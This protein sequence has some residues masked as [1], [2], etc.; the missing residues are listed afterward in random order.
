MRRLPLITLSTIAAVL[1]GTMVIAPGASAKPTVRPIAETPSGTVIQPQLFG[2][3]VFDVQNG[4]WPTIPIGALRLWDNQ[5]TW[6]AIEGTDNAF[7]WTRLDAAV[8]NAQQHGV[9]DILMVLAG[10]PAWVTDDPQS[11]GQAGVAPGGAGMPKDLAAWDDWVTQ[12]VTRYKGRI[13]AY[14]PWNEVNLP[15]FSTGSPAEMAE[16]T[17]RAYAII[18][19][20]DPSA[21]VVA[22]STG[23]RLQGAFLKFY[24]KFLAE[25]ASRGWPVDV[26]SVHTY[27][28]SLGTPADRAALAR[29]FEQVLANAGAPAKPIWDTENNFGLKGPGPANPDIDLTGPKAA[30]WL[31]RSYLDSLRLGIARTYW[32]GWGPDNDLLGIQMNTGS[33]GA[34]AFANLE[35]WIVGATYRGC[36]TAGTR[37]TCSFTRN[38]VPFQVLFT[39]SGQTKKF[40]VTGTQM[41]YLDGRCMKVAKKKVAI[42][43]PVYVGP[44]LAS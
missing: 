41:C 23:T 37:V 3:H 14:Q 11:G 30:Q 38:G 1:A 20:I 39:D 6:N 18:K 12:V 15:T 42:S 40:T 8:A 35:R 33:P 43:G 31:A 10:T 17:K 27:P 25:L 26:W 29:G 24:P 7:D 32:Y 2:M 19:R 4:V 5:T 44:A 21:T 22:P 9:K 28:A 16:L 34:V 36:T 13:T